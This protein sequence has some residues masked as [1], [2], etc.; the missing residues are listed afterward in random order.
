MG[1]G[2]EGR[3][4]SGNDFPGVTQSRKA[5]PITRGNTNLYSYDL[6]PNGYNAAFDT[7]AIS[8]HKLP[9][10]YFAPN[11]YGLYDMAGN[12]WEWCWDWYGSPI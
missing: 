9:V 11:G 4:E 8:R 5:R 1:E 3:A 2:G 6:K 7:P 10:G 12:V